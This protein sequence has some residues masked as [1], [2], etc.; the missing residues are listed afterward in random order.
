MYYHVSVKDLGHE[1][2]FTPNLP[3]CSLLSKEG[4]IPRICVSKE[5]ALCLQSIVSHS[6]ISV[7]EVICEICDRTDL[8]GFE[9][10][11]DWMKKGAKLVSPAVYRCS[12]PAYLPP[13][14]SDFRENKEHWYL[15]PT[16]FTRS[17]YIDLN[18]LIETGKVYITKEQQQIN[19]T[20]LRDET[21]KSIKVK[22]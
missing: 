21:L 8:V 13:D 11:E 18:R 4:N 15:K 10:V 2:T 19:G 12:E 6:P 16:E 7:W 17:G 20:Y 9:T 1:V 14:A 5:L 22:R 3:A